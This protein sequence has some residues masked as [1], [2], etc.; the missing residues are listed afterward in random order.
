MEKEKIA[1]IMDHTL[2]KP[3]VLDEQIEVL[4]AEAK[5]YGFASVCVNP[6]YT[7]KVRELLVGTRIRVCTVI[8]FPL[9]ATTSA[10]K[11]FEAQEALRLGADELDY[12]VNIS[13]VLNG[14]FG[15]VRA[16]MSQ[17][18]QLKGG[19]SQVLVKIILE[20]CYLS[21]DQITKLCVMA[22]SAGLDFV[23][24]STGFG[25]GGASTEHVTLMRHAVGQ[26]LGVKASGGIRTY[27]DAAKMVEAGASRIGA[28]AS[29]A[30]VR[31]ARLLSVKQSNVL[32]C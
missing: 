9:G 4:C 1:G 18:A 22:K 8:G 6:T 7:K 11:I 10:T 29:V 21:E 20:T 24:T 16:E 30:I 17:F 5:E 19:N 3:N 14:R 31:T 12:V 32:N 15:E 23:K 27:E 26:A 2:L 25:S 13:D 28:S